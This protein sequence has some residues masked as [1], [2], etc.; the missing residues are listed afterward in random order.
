M[1]IFDGK[2]KSQSTIQNIALLHLL[3][4]RQFC[5]K[6]L[7]T[8]VK[9]LQIMFDGGGFESKHG[10]S[11]LWG[12]HGVRR[13]N[14]IWAAIVN[15]EMLMWNW[16]F[17]N[18]IEIRDCNPLVLLWTFAPLHHESGTRVRG[19]IYNA[20]TISSRQCVQT[21]SCHQAHTSCY[22]V[23]AMHKLH[24]HFLLLSPL[25]VPKLQPHAFW[26]PLTAKHFKN[27]LKYL[28]VFVVVFGVSHV[29]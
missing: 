24:G 1:T 6:T 3:A 16:F 8:L 29:T 7:E 2:H 5:F 19:V 22:K 15:C 10:K 4:T 23:R 11:K 28:V 26:E 21:V 18:S 20:N 17:C 14:G 13:K 27:G 9:L 12:P 25:L